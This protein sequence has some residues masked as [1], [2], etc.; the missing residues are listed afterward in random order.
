MDPSDPLTAS[1]RAAVR[2][3]DTATLRQLLDDHPGVAAEPIRDGEG[4]SRTLLHDVTDWPGY[5]PSGPAITRLL[6]AAGADPNVRATGGRQAETPLHWAASSDDADVAAEL[7]SG[8]A[9][10]EAPDG[11][12]GTPLQNAVGYGCWN[13]ARLLAARGAAVDT[14]WTAAA[15]GLMTRVEELAGQAP[16]PSA[17]DLNEAFWQACHGGQRRVAEYLLARG[18]D[19]SATPGYSDQTP[20]EAAADL[21]TRRENLI[22]WLRE[23][24][25]T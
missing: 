11:S 10:L 4:K 22:A 24:S 19:L 8:G 14:L 13:V 16:A 6:L 17:D 5:F 1:L 23:Q 12:I 25:R 18:A 15:L 2:S 7:I 3:G 9:D 20:A 21:G